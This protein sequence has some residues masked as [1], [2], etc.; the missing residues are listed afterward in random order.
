MVSPAGQAA[1][2]DNAAIVDHR[3]VFVLALDEH[4]PSSELLDALLSGGMRPIVVQV[5]RAGDL[6]DPVRVRAAIVVGSARSE[7][8]ELPREDD[9]KIDWLQ[10]ADTS[11]TTVMAIGHAARLLAVAFG[12]RM[13]PAERPLRGWAMVDTSVPHLIPAGP[14]LT[15][16][17]DLIWLPVHANVLAHNRLGPQVF[18][19]G[20]HLGVMFHPEATRQTSLAWAELIDHRTCLLDGRDHDAASSSARRL[21]ATFL[22]G[23]SAPDRPPPDN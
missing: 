3:D 1:L 7:N 4:H 6:P 15:W 23:I 2:S 11:G 16:Q 9:A 13:M 20:R 18:G 12:G 19:L 14:W 17:H 22:S 21:L 10:R 5:R 8:A